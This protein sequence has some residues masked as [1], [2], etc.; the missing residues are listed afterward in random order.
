MRSLLFET[1]TFNSQKFEIRH[2]ID[3]D[4]ITVKVFLNNTQVG[5][6]YCCP[7]DGLSSQGCISSLELLK[8]QVKS[9]IQNG[10]I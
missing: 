1:Y 6:E 10:K 3:N 5:Y 8:R 9:D 7:D 4:F 2:K